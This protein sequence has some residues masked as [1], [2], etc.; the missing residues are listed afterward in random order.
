MRSSLAFLVATT[1]VLAA[2]GCGGTKR[3]SEAPPA[4]AG[5]SSGTTN[6]V[7]GTGATA[8]TDPLPGAGTVPVV[9]NPTATETA[10]LTRVD[11][12]A[13]AG[14]ERVVF[15]FQKDLTGYDVRYVEPPIY[16]DGSG[17]LVKIAGNAVLLVRLE[18]ASGFD[19]SGE[20]HQVYKGPRRIEGGDVGTSLVREVVRSGD[21]E[22]VTTWA[23]GLDHRVPFLVRT[24]DDPTRLVVDLR[25]S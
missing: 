22:G 24:L 5:T 14:Y 2:S 11:V 13:H 10:L 9:V 1:I 25:S 15:A 23:I 19:F 8:A 7:V 12:G 16:E 3:G 18:P 21:F 20:G 6:A 17:A 4:S